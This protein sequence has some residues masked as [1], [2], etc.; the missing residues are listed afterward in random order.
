MRIM[1]LAAQYLL[2][3]GSTLLSLGS[4]SD[5]QFLRRSGSSVVGAGDSNG[6]LDSYVTGGSA[7]FGDGS[8]GD[9]NI[10]TP[11]TLTADAFYNNLSVTSTLDT[12]GYKVYV[13]GTLSG[14]GTIR[15]N[16]NNGNNGTGGAGL[17]TRG[18]LNTDSG[19]GG[20]GLSS[21]GA[22]SAGGNPA[23]SVWNG[24][25]A[26]FAGGSGGS[27]A[28]GA[29]GSGATPTVRAASAGSPRVWHNAVT[30]HSVSGTGT[31]QP[32]AGGGGGGGGGCNI[33]TGTARSGG[34]GSGGGSVVVV[35]RYV[36]A[37]GLTIS[38]N[39]GDGA[40]ASSITG[41]GAAGGGGG[42]GG[43]YVLLCAGKVINAPTLS[44]AGGTGGAGGG[45]G[46]SG[47]NGSSGF[48]QT[49]TLA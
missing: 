19:A 25:G 10:N 14:T 23:G 44:A 49:L 24:S 31:W 8:A 20:N 11:T 46:P 48:T 43:G 26:S 34:G 41:N 18:T 35:A 9:G 1:R 28:S 42:G 16:G 47:S 32:A 21:T 45:G 4:V 5:L 29:G 37:S 36:D 22:G 15:D 2:A 33:G 39:G 6:L 40:A 27:V 12:A 30:G 7:L 17:G 38:A 13:R 3:A